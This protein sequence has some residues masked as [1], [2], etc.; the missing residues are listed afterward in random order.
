MVAVATAGFRVAAETNSE[1][2][3]SPVELGGLRA[4][5]EPEAANTNVGVSQILQ[6]KKAPAQ[7]GQVIF[8]GLTRGNERI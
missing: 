1:W 3:R 4:A 8:K 5:V 6:L 7:L 2:E